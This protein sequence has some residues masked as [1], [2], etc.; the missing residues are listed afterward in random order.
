[1]PFYLWKC[2]KCDEV[3]EYFQTMTERDQAP[4]SHCLDCDP[5]RLEEGTLFQT[6]D[7]D[8][9]PK[10]RVMGPGAYYPNKMQ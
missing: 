6:Y 1:M 2:K 4:P 5:E 10:F 7:K 9:M 3:W 8:S